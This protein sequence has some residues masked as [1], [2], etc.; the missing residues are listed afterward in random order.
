MDK[1]IIRVFHYTPEQVKA[2]QEQHPDA[3]I[4][5]HYSPWHCEFSLASGVEIWKPILEEK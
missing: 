3:E 2:L 5:A 1:Q 4:Q